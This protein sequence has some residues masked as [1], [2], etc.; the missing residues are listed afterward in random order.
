MDK[1]LDGFAHCQELE[2]K[3]KRA[4]GMIAKPKHY[5]SQSDMLSFYNATFSPNMHYE[6]RIWGHT[7]NISL[8]KIQSLQ[9]SAIKN[10]E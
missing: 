9:H 6:C 1:F 7:T 4:I 5:L 10:D 2:V 8:K 3:L